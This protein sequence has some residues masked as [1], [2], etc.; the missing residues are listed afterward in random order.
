MNPGDSWG[1]E[2]ALLSATT[3]LAA[4]RVTALCKGCVKSVTA[5]LQRVPGV[6]N[7]GVKRRCWLSFAT[8][9][10]GVASVPAQEGPARPRHKVS[11][12]RL[13]RALSARF[14]LRLTAGGLLD[15]HV[16]APALLLLPAAQQLGA[17]LQAQLSGPQLRGVFTGEADLVFS[18]RYE[19]SDRTI[20]AH[21]PRVNALRL[22]GLPRETAQAMQAVLAAV[23][24]DSVGD[25]VL[26]RF[27]PHELAVADAMGIE[28]KEI[29][30]AEDGL[31]VYFGNA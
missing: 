27:E 24:Q 15:L 30:I 5:V 21:R 11:A 1:M 26:H 16:E 20:R 8:L 14:P 31:V 29:V 25:I 23:A 28:P 3:R 2:W 7:A 18:I 19:R 22:P 4:R 9:L 17:T 12:A 6:H 13:H 10:L